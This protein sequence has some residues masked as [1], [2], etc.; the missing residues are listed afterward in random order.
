MANFLKIEVELNS[1]FEEKLTLEHL[2]TFTKFN[3]N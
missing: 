3:M 1:H 2:G